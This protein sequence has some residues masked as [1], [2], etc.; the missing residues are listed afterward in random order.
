M[1]PR[2]PAP[3]S[4]ASAR[5]RAEK[6]SCAPTNALEIHKDDGLEVCPKSFPCR[7][8]IPGRVFFKEGALNLDG[9]ERVCLV[10]YG[11]VQ[12]FNEYL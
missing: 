4:C 9:F 8:M 7:M 2:T 10:L 3:D 5:Y 11:F 1:Y 6:T 12:L